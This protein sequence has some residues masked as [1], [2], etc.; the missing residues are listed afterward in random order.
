MND[1]SNKP[2]LFDGTW[3][4]LTGKPSFSTVAI[5]GSWNDLI[6]K[7]TTL[8]G[9]GITDA[10][11]NSHPASV[12]TAIDIT[13]WN[14]AF[15]WGNHSGLY[16]PVSY[17]PA[18]SE[19]IGKPTFATVATSGSYND[20]NNK[21][22]IDGS[23]TKVTGGTN[24]TVTGEGTTTNPYSINSSGASIPGNNSGDM[25]YWNG[26]SWVIVPVGSN[27]RVLTLVNGIPTWGSSVSDFHIG[28][29]YQGGIVACILQPGDP[30]YDANVQ[31]GL[32]AAPFDQEYAQWGCSG[33][34][35]SGADG[36]AIGRGAQNTID[37][38]TG[39]T[40]ADIA[41]KRCFDLE[42]NGYS[43]WYLPSKDELNK[44]Y[45]NKVAVGGFAI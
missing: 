2:A 42:L 35:I 1:L 45:I 3:S 37:I 29:S 19:I 21:P 34:T 13:N 18:W 17:V 32:I 41:A 36:T 20:L 15:S 23:E 16:R 14:S 9:Y 6:N 28:D 31:H 39:C 26:T 43:D 25:L 40:N 24:V 8:A 5:S 11:S 10:L 7:P 44:L 33:T 4:S 38:V 12:I 22:T 30:G 27:G